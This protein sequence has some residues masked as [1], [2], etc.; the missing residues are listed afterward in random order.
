[1][2]AVWVA[3]LGGLLVG[4]ILWLAAISVAIE[5]SNVSTWVLVVAALSVLVGVA[6][7]FAGRA[8]WQRHRPNSRVWTAFWWLLPVSPVLLSLTVL[9]VTYL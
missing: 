6:A 9:G 3:G 5:T 2:R 4:H 7:G 8:A 1:M